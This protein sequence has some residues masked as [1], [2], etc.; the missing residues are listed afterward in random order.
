M[1]TIPDGG[2]AGPDGGMP[3][4]PDAGNPAMISSDE[5]ARRLAKLIWDTMPD[6][7][8]LAQAAMIKTRDD[9]GKLAQQM[10][11]DPRARLGVG[12]FYRQWL[13]LDRVP[14]VLKDPAAF[15]QW[16]AAVSADGARETE[17]FAVDV[18]LDT[19]GTFLTL[20]TGP[21]SY[22]NERLAPLYGISGITGPDLRK[23]DL[24]GKQRGGLLTQPA[25]LAMSGLARP[26]PTLR[27]QYIREHFFCFEGLN[28]PP[29]PAP[30]LPPPLPANATFRQKLEGTLAANN[31]QGGCHV[32]MDP[33]GY[34][35]DGFDAIGRART[36]DNGS[37]VDLTGTVKNGAADIA[38]NGPI[39]LGKVLA[40]H[41]D[42]QRCLVRQWASYAV[43]RILKSS[44]LSV[45][46]SLRLAF[47]NGGG[48]L[49][50]LI[51]SV[52][53]SPVV[54]TP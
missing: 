6:A 11:N 35:Y 21:F 46:E 8:L 3:A 31:C 33:L 13:G 36:T 22:L 14:A 24:T 1:T 39:E 51:V 34:A 45:V 53:Q 26:S 10:L 38:F 12:A 49:R 2:T 23:V 43:G 37:P 28:S 7:A 30:N 47:K 20:M 42:V 41:D 50:A 9:V 16:T 44:E 32:L 15:P 27:G 18:T 19:S 29:P 5:I 4:M 40:D 48:N 54:L 25:L 52:A 17:M